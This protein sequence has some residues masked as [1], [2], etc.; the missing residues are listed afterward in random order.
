MIAHTSIVAG[1]TEE[2]QNVCY[3]KTKSKRQLSMCAHRLSCGSFFFLHFERILRQLTGFSFD[4]FMDG[5]VFFLRLMCR[6]FRIHMNVL[7]LRNHQHCFCGSF[8]SV[9]GGNLLVFFFSNTVYDG[10]LTLFWNCLWF[11]S[12]HDLFF[13][14]FASPSTPPSYMLPNYYWCCVFFCYFI[15]LVCAP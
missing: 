10:L 7:V 4:V 11:F 2:K 9:I 14:F 13:Q 8:R 12:P 5:G 6:S 3:I 1:G 15:T